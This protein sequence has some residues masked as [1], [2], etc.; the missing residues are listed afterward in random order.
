MKIDV[1]LSFAYSILTAFA[2]TGIIILAAPTHLITNDDT[3]QVNEY[4]VDDYGSF[5]IDIRLGDVNG[6]LDGLYRVGTSSL[7]SNVFVTVNDPTVVKVYDSLKGYMVGMDDID[8]AQFLL[9]FVQNNIDYERDEFVY[10]QQ[11]YI[12]YPAETLLLKT[13]DCEDMSFLLLTLYEKAGLDAVIIQAE[14]HTSVGVDI[15]LEKGRYV[16]A[17]GSDVRYYI[18][19]PTGYYPV[20]VDTIEGLMFVHHPTVPYFAIVL[21]LTGLLV[22]AIITYW[23]RDEFVYRAVQI[24]SQ[25]SFMEVRA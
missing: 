18:A 19:E 17:L 4:Q 2:I 21:I 14:D 12:Q 9:R 15:P 13:G 24:D 1:G 7:L 6:Y 3:I 16:T 10:G 8:K 22:S 25:A 20:G 23:N 11:D 5:D